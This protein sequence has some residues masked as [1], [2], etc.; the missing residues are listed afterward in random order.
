GAARPRRQRDRHGTRIARSKPEV[1]VFQ[2]RRTG[3]LSYLA[4][5]AHAWCVKAHAPGMYDQI[6]HGSRACVLLDA[7]RL[8]N[9]DC[10]F[11]HVSW[12]QRV[13]I[14]TQDTTNQAA[15][16]CTAIEH[17]PFSPCCVGAPARGSVA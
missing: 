14:V 1:N 3:I 9:G 2:A 7:Y 13:L 10:G 15:L 17:A 12:D 16:D 4:A 5:M 6:T 11:E 8:C